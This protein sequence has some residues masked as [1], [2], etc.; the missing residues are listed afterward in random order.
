MG[1]IKGKLKDII[2]D[3]SPLYINNGYGRSLWLG[4]GWGGGCGPSAKVGCVPWTRVGLI[5]IKVFSRD[6]ASKA[7]TFYP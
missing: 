4:N 5:I 7:G 1:L 3:C 6:L 2:I